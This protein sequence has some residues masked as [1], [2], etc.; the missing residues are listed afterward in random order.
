M[1]K[2]YLPPIIW[3]SKD[4]CVCKGVQCLTERYVPDVDED[5]RLKSEKVIGIERNYRRVFADIRQGDD[6]IYRGTVRIYADVWYKLNMA[7]ASLRTCMR[8]M[9]SKVERFFYSKCGHYIWSAEAEKI[10]EDWKNCK[11]NIMMYVPKK[12]KKAKRNSLPTLLRED[13][14]E[15]NLGMNTVRI[16]RGC[17]D[18]Q[19]RV[20]D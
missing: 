3:C 2:D 4:R 5:G 17:E 12:E 6:G 13:A 7:A 10:Y 14:D 1:G 16:E 11:V 19:D 20:L 15:Y 9:N 8:R 18:E